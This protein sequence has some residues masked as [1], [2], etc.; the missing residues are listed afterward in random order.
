MKATPIKAK[1][2]LRIVMSPLSLPVTTAQSRLIAFIRSPPGWA[3]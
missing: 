1:I 2:A 3:H